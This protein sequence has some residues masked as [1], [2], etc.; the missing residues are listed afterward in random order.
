MSTKEDYEAK[1]GIITVIPDDQ[2]RTP[3]NI[4]MDVYVQEAENLYH[5]CQDDREVLTAKGLNWALVDDLPIRCGAL[6]EAESLWNKERFSKEEA[7]KQWKEKSPLAYELRNTLLH[8][9]R[10]A[11]RNDEVLLGR[12]KAIAEG[13]TNADMIQDLNDLSVLGLA[14]L[15]P[16]VAVDFDMSL[17]DQAAPTADEMAALLAAATGDRIDTSESKKIRDQAY[18][19]LKEAVDEIYDY[20]K[21]AFWQDDERLKGYRSHYLR[22]IRMRNASTPEEQDVSEGQTPGTGG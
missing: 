7:E 13:S 18:T 17:L 9:F 3:D 10:F 6:R 15:E 12:V 14:N 16:L 20:G 4:P 1:L 5:W 22:R 8:H 2:I 21:Y 19:H 11:Y